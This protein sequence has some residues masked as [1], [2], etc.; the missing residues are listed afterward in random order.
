MG[1]VI[2]LSVAVDLFDVIIASASL[3]LQFTDNKFASLSI[4]LTYA[5]LVLY[6][7]L[8]LK[9]NNL[10]LERKLTISMGSCN[11]GEIDVPNFLKT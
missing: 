1:K 3:G 10:C 7:L 5:L 9:E 2:L 4:F 6:E 8:L 11:V